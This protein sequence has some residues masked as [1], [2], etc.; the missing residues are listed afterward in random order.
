MLLAANLAQQHPAQLL[1]PVDVLRVVLLDHAVVVALALRVGRPV[2]LLLGGPVALH[3]AFLIDHIEAIGFRRE[4]GEEG[5]QRLR[6]GGRRVRGRG[7]EVCSRGAGDP[8]RALGLVCSRAQSA[9]LPTGGCL[10][11]VLAL[12]LGDIA[13]AI[14]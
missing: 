1:P 14:P 12:H 2:E 6:H 5:R 9:V 7:A 11:D 13:S 8:S 10:N 3:I 4:D